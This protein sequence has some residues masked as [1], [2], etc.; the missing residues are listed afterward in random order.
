MREHANERH[1]P[2]LVDLDPVHGAACRQPAPF[3]R[4]ACSS[5]VTALP[6]ALPFVAFMTRPTSAPAARSSPAQYFAHAF[7]SAAMASA[8]AAS[9]DDVSSASYPLATAI[10]AG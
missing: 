2:E 6:S 1:H 3:A 4:R 9:I 5:A 10:A 7:G 8:T